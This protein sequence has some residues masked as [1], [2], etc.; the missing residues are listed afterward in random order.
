MRNAIVILAALTA[1]ASAQT[2]AG[3]PQDKPEQ[4]QRF[5]RQEVTVPDFQA[6]GYILD[7][8]GGGEGI[9]GRLKPTQVV[10]IDLIKRE[11]AE[12]PPGPLKIVMDATDLKFLD[13]S[14]NTVTAFF[15]LMYVP[16]P[17]K[18][19]VFD[20]AMRVLAPGGR[21]LIWDAVIPAR[22]D[23]A[24]H[25]VVFPMRIK[26]PDE[27]VN[28]GYGAYWPETARDPAYYI[29]MATKAGFKVA[30][31]QETGRTFYLELRK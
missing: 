24:K 25:D 20:E 31:R 15:M 9:I 11:L 22:T 4:V 3:H 6:S 10:A 29:E 1:V 8:G 27:T 5:E 26:L 2:E 12:A 23:P 18:Q 21:F 30:A 19:K 16:Q 7:L 28:T 17:Q 14:F 13:G